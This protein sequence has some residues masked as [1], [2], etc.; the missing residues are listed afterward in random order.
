MTPEQVL[1]REGLALPMSHPV[2]ANY[3]KTVRK[4]ALGPGDRRRGSRRRH[5]GG[6]ERRAQLRRNSSV[7]PLC[8]AIPN[9]PPRTEEKQEGQGQVR[10]AFDAL[11]YPKPIRRLVDDVGPKAQAVDTASEC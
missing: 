3:A 2:V 10:A 8:V 5:A 4:G 11:I 7:T 1:E 6:C 9:L